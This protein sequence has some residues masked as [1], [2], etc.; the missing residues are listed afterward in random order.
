MGLNELYRLYENYRIANAFTGNPVNLYEPMN[1]I[2][3]LGGK[4]AR[5]MLTL[6]SCLSAGGNPENALP[7]AHALE[8][9]HNFTLLHDDIMDNANS[10]RG[11]LTVHVKWN[12]AIAILSGD[13]MLVSAYH[14]LNLVEHPRKAELFQLFS[15]TAREVCEGQQM[16]MDFSTSENI[17]ESDYLEMIRLKTAVL[18]GNCAA[19]GSIIANQSAE[20]AQLY[21]DFAI[22]M[23][24]AFQ[25][26]DD[27]L[28]TFGDETKTG[29]KAGGDIAENKKTWLV[30]SAMNMSKDFAALLQIENTEEKIMK[31]TRAF[32]E[33]KL[34]EALQEKCHEYNEKAV[35]ILKQ[36]ESQ[37]HNTGILTELVS[38]LKN[39]QH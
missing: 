31:V 26:Q 5:P 18:L 7:V 9:F 12:T 4:R 14:H 25:L 15:Q 28:D 11:K 38:Y 6:A 22:A 37:G 10:R 29:K 24:M 19:S 39:R 30:I 1:Y 35:D 3:D 2:M 20:T 16:D 13:N 36:I 33:L 23:G 17:S 32:Q 21:Y 8:V 27:Y 34:D